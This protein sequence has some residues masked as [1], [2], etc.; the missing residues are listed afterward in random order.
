MRMWDGKAVVCRRETPRTFN[1]IEVERELRR[2]SRDVLP[3]FDNARE[4][5]KRATR[6]RRALSLSLILH[7]ALQEEDQK[8]ECKSQN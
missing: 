5:L 6:F 3:R 4:A 8:Q 7:A 1:A 2:A